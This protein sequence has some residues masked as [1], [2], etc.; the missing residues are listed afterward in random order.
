LPNNEENKTYIYTVI[1]HLKAT[2]YYQ[3]NRS[4]AVLFPRLIWSLDRNKT[5]YILGFISQTVFCFFNLATCQG[6]ATYFCPD[7]KTFISRSWYSVLPDLDVTISCHIKKMVIGM[8][9]L[10][11]ALNT[12]HRSVA[13]LVVIGAY[14]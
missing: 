11:A 1:L 8:T 7:H 9:Q 13:F 3:Q 10:I 12:I 14:G 2:K 4:F 6:M 5:H